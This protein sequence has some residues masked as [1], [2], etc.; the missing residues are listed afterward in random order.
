VTGDRLCLA[1]PELQEARSEHQRAGEGREC[2]LQVDDGRAGKV[3]EAILREPAATPRPVRDD[4]VDDAHVDDAEHDV[5]REL[6]AVEHRAV[7]DRQRHRGEHGLEEE[8]GLGAPACAVVDSAEVEEP[9]GGAEEVV[10]LAESKRKARR[11]EHQECNGEVHDDLACNRSRVLHTGEAGLQEEEAG[12]HEE[13][14]DA[15]ENDPQRVERDVGLDEVP[16]LRSRQ[17]WDA[18]QQHAGRRDDP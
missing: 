1:V 18:E 2:T 12:L 16:V 17:A 8:E 13:D 7:D 10:A 15:A 4:R 5:G 6:C 14:E 3:Q 11:P 9:P